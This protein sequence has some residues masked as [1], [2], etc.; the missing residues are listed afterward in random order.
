MDSYLCGG[1]LSSDF[2]DILILQGKQEPR[3]DAASREATGKVSMSKFSVFNR[4]GSQLR[5]SAADCQLLQGRAQVFLTG[6]YAGYTV[7]G[8]SNPNLFVRSRHFTFVFHFNLRYEG[9]LKLW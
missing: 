5:H 9:N 1:W 3:K 6:K 8:V 4:A 2:S 7:N